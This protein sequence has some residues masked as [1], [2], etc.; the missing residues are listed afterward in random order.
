MKALVVLLL[1]SGCVSFEGVKMDDEERKA[2]AIETCSVYTLR[3]LRELAK[4]F[5]LQGFAA[6]SRAVREEIRACCS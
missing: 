6:S 5:F 1:L 4:R 2:C 3:E